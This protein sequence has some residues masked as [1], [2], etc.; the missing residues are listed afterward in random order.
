MAHFAYDKCFGLIDLPQKGLEDNT[1][2][3]EKVLA[4]RK[5]ICTTHATV[6][7]GL[8]VVE[9]HK[10]SKRYGRQLGVDRCRCASI[11]LNIY[12]LKF[13]KQSLYIQ[14]LAHF[15]PCRLK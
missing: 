6:L 5:V 10:D 7:P 3:V 11:C 2:Y 15:L 1:A 8:Y 14:W 9:T 13:T 12:Y 4:V